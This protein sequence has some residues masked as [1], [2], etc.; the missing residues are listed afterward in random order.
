MA[1]ELRLVGSVAGD[2][3]CRGLLAGGWLGEPRL[4]R[5]PAAGLSDSAGLTRMEPGAGR[6]RA[7]EAG[8]AGR[9]R[10]RLSGC[11]RLGGEETGRLA[12][13]EAARGW[14]VSEEA[15][16]EPRLELIGNNYVCSHL[17]LL[18]GLGGVV[19]L[20]PV[21]LVTSEIGSLDW[22]VGGRRSCKQ[23]IINTKHK[24][25]NLFNNSAKTNK[26]DQKLH[27]RWPFVMNLFCLACFI[28]IF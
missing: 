15:E 2:G 11:C 5:D 28:F 16:L 18:A 26:L 24:I 19:T 23:T 14:G 8:A 22:R 4:S 3:D 27:S 1:G 6:G 10:S 17:A 13:E 9:G 20:L 21:L 25:R 12:R 7:G